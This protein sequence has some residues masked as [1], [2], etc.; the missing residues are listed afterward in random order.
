MHIHVL[1]INK[2]V[3][4]DTQSILKLKLI[5]KKNDNITLIACFYLI[6]SK[7]WYHNHNTNIYCRANQEWQWQNVLFTIVK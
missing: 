4:L 3:L 6:I 1:L 7:M 2:T 5:G